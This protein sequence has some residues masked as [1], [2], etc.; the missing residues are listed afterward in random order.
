MKRFRPQLVAVRNE[1]L[2]NQLKEALSDADY[3]P[4]IIPR[5]QGVIE[6]IFYY[7][8]TNC[9]SDENQFC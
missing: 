3:K 8:L 1:S 6:V 9:L 4:E 5:E 7:F 2:I